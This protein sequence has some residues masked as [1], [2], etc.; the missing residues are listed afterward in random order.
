MRAIELGK[1]IAPGADYPDQIVRKARLTLE[2]RLVASVEAA[3]VAMPQLLSTSER[4]H[5]DMKTRPSASS[6]PE[7]ARRETTLDPNEG[8][9][10]PIAVKPELSSARRWS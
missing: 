6:P 7:S 5:A 3:G 2:E 9:R 1:K 8:A 4:W 10:I